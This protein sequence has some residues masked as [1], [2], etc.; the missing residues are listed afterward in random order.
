MKR[1]IITAVI[2]IVIEFIYII[3][4]VIDGRFAE[5]IIDIGFILLFMLV[6]AAFKRPTIPLAITFAAIGSFTASVCIAIRISEWTMWALSP[7]VISPADANGIKIG[8][9]CCGFIY[10]IYNAFRCAAQIQE[11]KEEN[12]ENGYRAAVVSRS[13][14]EKTKFM[15]NYLRPDHTGFILMIAAALLGAGS[16]LIVWLSDGK[17][18]TDAAL[19]II[20]YVV[21]ICVL[22]GIIIRSRRGYQSYVMQ[23]SNSGELSRMAEDY[24]HGRR[25]WGSDIVL[26]EHYI[27]AKNCTRVHK[28]SDIAKIYHEWSDLDTMR[29]SPWWHLRMIT[30]DGSDYLLA[31]VPYRHTIEN[32]NEYVLPVILEIRSRNSQVV[33]EKFDTRPFQVK[34]PLKK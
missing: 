12:F 11:M 32:F 33:I 27:F 22:G 15:V 8:V 29:H 17:K 13:V 34:K 28:Y 10:G 19:I 7:S 6:I 5:G 21:I 24:T 3:T 4:E 18:E 26:G 23:L 16:F 31:F 2:A 9:Y 1:H 25:Y 20:I 14:D 30:N